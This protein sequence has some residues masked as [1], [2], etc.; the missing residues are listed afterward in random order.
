LTAHQRTYIAQNLV[1]LGDPKWTN[2]KETCFQT[3]LNHKDFGITFQ[4]L[5]ILKLSLGP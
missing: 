2:S 1:D 3:A 5:L 4:D